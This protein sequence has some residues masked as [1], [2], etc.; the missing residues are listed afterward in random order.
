MRVE[1]LPLERQ[2]RFQ[3]GP[4]AADDLPT[5]AL[6]ESSRFSRENAWIVDVR[7]GPAWQYINRDLGI[8][9]P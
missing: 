9:S 6:A 2:R 8:M 4:G 7:H 5:A 1:Q 3:V